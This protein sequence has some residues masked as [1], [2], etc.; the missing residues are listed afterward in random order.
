MLEYQE[1][2]PMEFEY[3]SPSSTGC[4][5]SFHSNNEQK[6]TPLPLGSFPV[7]ESFF[8]NKYNKSTA[9][10]NKIADAFTFFTINDPENEQ[11]P[12]GLEEVPTMNEAQ[13][14]D[15]GNDAVSARFHSKYISQLLLNICFSRNIDGFGT[16]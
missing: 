3:T 16:L 15:K 12:A 10:A 13:P 2:E 11:E 4:R 9:I 7:P 6:Y 8:E 5:S 14:V 1:P